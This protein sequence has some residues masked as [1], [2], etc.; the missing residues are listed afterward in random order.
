[1]SLVLQW[2][3]PYPSLL[4]SNEAT[5]Q[6]K[7]KANRKHTQGRI[8]DFRKEGVQPMEKGTK[9]ER[10]RRSAGAGGLGALPQANLKTRSAYMRFPDIWECDTMNLFS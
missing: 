2:L 1:M 4:F 5:K 6:G 7:I 3:F 8:Q 9:A 10:R